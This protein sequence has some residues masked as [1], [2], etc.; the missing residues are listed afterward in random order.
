MTRLH[1]PYFRMLLV[2]PGQSG[3][4]GESLATILSVP[5]WVQVAA[6]LRN[7]IYSGTYPAWQALPGELRLT[8]EF[9]ASRITIRRALA[10][11]AAEG[12]IVR[13]QGRH[14]IV[15]NSI[16]QR[17]PAATGFVE[18]LVT[19]FQATRLTSYA[20]DQVS[21]TDVPEWAAEFLRTLH[22]IH[23][24]R[25]RSLNGIPFAVADS[26]LPAKLGRKLNTSDLEQFQMLELLDRKL[27]APVHEAE[28][29][30]EAVGAPA[31]VA[32]RLAVDP[33][34]P[35]MRIDLYYRARGG[36]PVAAS[37]VH[38]RGDRYVYRVRLFR[39]TAVALE[40]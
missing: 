11:L 8:R 24:Q 7:R 26:Y 23:V 12:L 3:Q 38:V 31:D 27:G 10:Q 6:L 39:R 14:T 17:L 35:V 33:G 21:S 15:S 29:H 16:P 25:T 9:N 37:R 2:S 19:L 32:V 36:R 18:D 5:L 1:V 28:Q 20:I 4:A 13:R 40:A 22:A 34:R 30:I